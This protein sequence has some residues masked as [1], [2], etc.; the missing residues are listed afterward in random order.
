MGLSTG[1]KGPRGFSD[2]TVRMKTGKSSEEWYALLDT[3]NAPEK[4]HTATAKHLC[5][6]HGVSPWWAQSVTVRY[7]YARGLRHPPAGTGE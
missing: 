5:E 6:A 4:G 3:W 7:E 2:E 1:T